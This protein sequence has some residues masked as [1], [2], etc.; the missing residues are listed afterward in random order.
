MIR[1]ITIRNENTYVIN[2]YINK[3]IK[4]TISW[5]HTWPVGTCVVVR[6]SVITGIDERRLS[7]NLRQ[8]KVGD[9]SGTTTADLRHDIVPNY[10]KTDFVTI[11]TWNNNLS[12]K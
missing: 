9:F 8:V 6:D 3:Y 7:K 11:F 2:D 4:E 1:N 12:N 5:E 10:K